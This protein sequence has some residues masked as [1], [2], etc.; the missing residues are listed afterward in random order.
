MLF[1]L[2]TKR[3]EELSEMLANLRRWV[4]E[5]EA[6]DLEA[7]EPLFAPEGKHVG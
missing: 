4:E 1:Q 6:L 5:L 7:Y 2:T 3:R